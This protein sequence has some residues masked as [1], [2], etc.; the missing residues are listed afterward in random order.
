[1][2]STASSPC[3][4]EDK[5]RQPWWLLGNGNKPVLGR[6]MAV[7]AT[8]HS[9]LK[10][11]TKLLSILGGN[12]LL[13]WLCMLLE[14]VLEGLGIG[15]TSTCGVGQI[16]LQ[17]LGLIGCQLPAFCPCSVVE[18]GK[19][20]S[21]TDHERRQVDLVHLVIVLGLLAV[22]V[23]ALCGLRWHGQW[24]HRQRGPDG[25]QIATEKQQPA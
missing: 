10:D 14:K 19:V 3:R 11:P 9:G 2:P 21:V 25:C 7:I 20:I 15:A 17:L 8:I 4:R 1:M 13:Q 16:F 22:P 18:R 12:G 5:N 6:L 24:R 23:M